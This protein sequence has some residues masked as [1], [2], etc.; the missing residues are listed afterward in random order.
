[1]KVP[2]TFSDD[3]DT[4]P[5]PGIR[6]SPMHM[7]MA[8]AMVSDPE[9]FK[10]AMDTS[11]MRRSTNIEDDRPVTFRESVAPI[12]QQQQQDRIQAAKDRIRGRRK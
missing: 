10:L 6:P 1:M 5:A 7:L 12:L 3:D 4:A 8:Q 11:Q 2:T 9:R